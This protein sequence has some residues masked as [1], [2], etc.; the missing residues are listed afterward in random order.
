MPA[1]GWKL[2]IDAIII[3]FSSP[4]SR[5]VLRLFC[6]SNNYS[7]DKFCRSIDELEVE[8]DLE[9]GLRSLEAFAYA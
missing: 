4:F 3:G 1:I 6:C 8:T 9:M 2:S 7:R 5:R